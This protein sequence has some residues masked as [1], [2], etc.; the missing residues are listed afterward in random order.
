MCSS[1]MKK[2]L[3]LILT[4]LYFACLP[5]QEKSRQIM[6][7]GYLTS[8]ESAM[9]DTLSGP[10]VFDNILHNRVNLKV[11]LNNHI[12]IAAELRNRLFTGD[13]PRIDASY[14]ARISADQGWADL[15]WNLISE[16]SFFLNTTLDRVWADF[17]YDKIQV[18]VGRQRINWGQTL[19]WNPNDVFNAYS[20]FDFDY[21]ERPGSDAVRVQ[22]Y[23]TS[24]SAIEMAAKI[25]HENHVTAASLYRFNKWGYD[26][27]LLAGYSNSSDLFAGAGWSGAIGSLSFRGEGTWFRPLKSFADT[28]GTTIITAGIDKIFNNNSTIQTQLMYC[29]NPLKINGFTSL[30]TG[31][32]SAKDLAFSKFTAFCQFTWAA[33]PLLNLGISAMWIPDLKG[34]FT[35]PSVDYSLAENIDF[36]LLWQ[37]FNSII[38]GTRTRINLAFLRMKFSF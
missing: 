26:L 12:T 17:N 38:N 6:V 25:N 36:S 35:G 11:F 32:L 9:F 8:L 27:Q 4:F 34:Y 37:H 28:I 18:T 5:A 24:S 3:V 7:S 33:S 29:N 13:M 20:F 23:P 14:S 22:Y 21:V 15:S 10:F 1:I 31:D 19:I 2:T 16:S 30:Y